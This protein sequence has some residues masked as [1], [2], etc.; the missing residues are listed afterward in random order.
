MRQTEAG[1]AVS[2]RAHQL[3]SSV[4]NTIV[5]TRS[6]ARAGESSR[7]VSKRRRMQ[8]GAMYFAW[9]RE[10]DAWNADPQASSR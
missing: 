3:E 4:Q 6:V 1:G 10:V 5:R 8:K 7:T 2:E 9:S